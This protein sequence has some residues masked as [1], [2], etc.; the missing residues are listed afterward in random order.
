MLVVHLG[1]FLIQR[2]MVLDIPDI[3]KGIGISL[4]FVGNKA[5]IQHEII[6]PGQ[7]PGPFTS[8]DNY[9]PDALLTLLAPKF[10]ALGAFSWFCG[11]V[12]VL[13]KEAGLVVEP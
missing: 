1:P 2:Q 8:L 6:L 9:T 7:V 10:L 5:I 11:V 3:H 13:L 12:A 4:L